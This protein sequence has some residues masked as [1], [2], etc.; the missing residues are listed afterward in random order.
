MIT[1]IS[2]TET[3][4]WGHV[5]GVGKGEEYNKNILCAKI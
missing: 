5:G 2:R 3:L 1:F 4:G